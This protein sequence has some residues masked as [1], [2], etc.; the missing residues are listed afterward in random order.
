MPHF[1]IDS[2]GAL[3]ARAGCS[4]RVPSEPM[5]EALRKNQHQQHLSAMKA[6]RFAQST[7]AFG[8]WQK[9]LSLSGQFLLMFVNL[10][11][12]KCARDQALSTQ[13]L[14][15]HCSKFGFWWFK[16]FELH[17]CSN[18]RNFLL[19]DGSPDYRYLQGWLKEDDGFGWIWVSC[20][21]PTMGSA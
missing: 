18:I 7:F 8:T 5:A 19:F 15:G 3:L 9:L 6:R 17:T 1:Q 10:Q 13:F 20:S 12:K 14:N 21:N 11:V 2:I 16:L 4:R